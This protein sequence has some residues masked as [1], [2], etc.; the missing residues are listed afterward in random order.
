M[1]MRYCSL[2]R[3]QPYRGEGSSVSLLIFFPAILYENKLPYLSG[4]K[5]KFNFQRLLRLLVLD[6]IDRTKYPNQELREILSKKL[7]DIK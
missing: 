3:Y 6:E 5:P 1:E 4:L 2:D 7:K